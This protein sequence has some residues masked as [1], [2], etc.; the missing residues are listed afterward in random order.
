MTAENQFEPLTPAQRAAIAMD[1]PKVH[2]SGTESLLPDPKQILLA[3]A[4]ACIADAEREE[5]SLATRLDAAI[6]ATAF[7]NKSV[8]DSL[9]IQRYLSRKYVQYTP[10]N[11][12]RKYYE[13][14]LALA[15]NTISEQEL[16]TTVAPESAVQLL[17]EL[18]NSPPGQITLFG[19]FCTAEDADT[20]L[21]AGDQ[22]QAA[23]DLLTK[24]LNELELK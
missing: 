7:L 22:L 23:R 16:S 4:R 2:D 12:L 9:L 17:D 5:N 6:Q 24:R 19:Q 21:N 3:H 13:H 15:K 8:L 11:E 14:A 18:R 20:V 1:A 10:E